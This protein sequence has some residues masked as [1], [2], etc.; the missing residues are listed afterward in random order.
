MK[1]KLLIVDDSLM[2]RKIV[3]QSFVKKNIQILEA[4]DGLEAIIVLNQNHKDIALVLTDLNMP[5]MNGYELLSHI[6]TNKTYMDIPV[7]ITSTESEKSNINRALKA[8]AA[9]YILKPFNTQDLIK[10]V[11]KYIK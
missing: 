7:V 4:V 8:G 2:I 9:E 10:I 1:D 6:K 3:K 5:K 11:D